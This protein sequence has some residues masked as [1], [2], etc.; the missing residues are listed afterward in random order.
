MVTGGLPNE[1]MRDIPLDGLRVGSGGWL[2]ERDRQQMLGSVE[3]FLPL[4][5]DQIGGSGLRIAIPEQCG[6]NL[7]AEPQP[8]EALL[9]SRTL[10]SVSVTLVRQAATHPCGLSGNNQEF[11]ASAI[12]S[13]QDLRG[14][15]KAVPPVSPRSRSLPRFG[16]C[17]S[18]PSC[19]RRTAQCS[20][21]TK[22]VPIGNTGLQHECVTMTREPDNGPHAQDRTRCQINRQPSPAPKKTVVLESRPSL[23]IRRPLGSTPTKVRSR[24]WHG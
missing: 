8:P 12:S 10:P 18:S 7:V 2:I 23:D 21:M 6:P 9:P 4:A 11:S 13:R 14:Y 17:V 24:A 15:G 16:E 22:I 5:N 19:L 20:G 3:L 1:G